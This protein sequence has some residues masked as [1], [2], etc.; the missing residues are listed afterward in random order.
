MSSEANYAADGRVI[1]QD[2]ALFNFIIRG[3]LQLVIFVIDQVWHFQICIDSEA[4][5]GAFSY[6][7]PANPQYP[8]SWPLT[9]GYRREPTGN[10]SFTLVSN[11]DRQD[12]A[13]THIQAHCDSFIKYSNYAL[14]SSS[15]EGMFKKNFR[16]IWLFTFLSFQYNLKIKTSKES[17]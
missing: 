10:G 6:G 1:I 13:A 15:F 5:L 7:N 8:Q 2:N 4:F 3:L 14:S 16:R 17:S 11:S 9:P 12:A